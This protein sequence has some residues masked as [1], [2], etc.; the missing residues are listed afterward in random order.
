MEQYE[1]SISKDTQLTTVAK[2]TGRLFWRNH[3]FN[4]V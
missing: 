4:V 1:R 3:G 2:G